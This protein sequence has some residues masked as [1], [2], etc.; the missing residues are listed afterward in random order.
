MNQIKEIYKLCTTPIISKIIYITLVLL[1]SLP[2]KKQVNRNSGIFG[3]GNKH[4]K[5]VLSLK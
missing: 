1:R 2:G 3:N 5:K 4:N